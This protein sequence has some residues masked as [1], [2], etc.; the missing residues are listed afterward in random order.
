[1][2]RTPGG[3]RLE[4]V[5]GASR[6][7][8]ARTAP[9][10]VGWTAALGIGLGLAAG[11]ASRP[12]PEIPLVPV[13]GWDYVEGRMPAPG[14]GLSE[15]ATRELAA[16]WALVVA[17]RLGEADLQ[18]SPL[19]ALAPDDPGVLSAAGFFALRRGDRAEAGE[20]FQRALD[21][22]PD[23]VLAS[24]GN[25]LLILESGD[26]ELRFTRLRRLSELDPDAS[27]V[28]ERLP[29]LTLEV[30]ENRLA[31]ARE[32][33]RS[34][35]RG[36]RVA[37]AYR[38]ALQAM[39]DSA[40]L[41]LEAAE[42]AAAAG[43][44]PSARAWFETVASN[45]AASRR[46]ALGAGLAAAELLADERRFTES[47]T[48]LDQI[49][50][51][52]A[53]RGS[54]DLV[55][56]AEDLERRL[57]VARLSELYGRIREAE[58][59]TREQLAALLA[60]EIG[61]P[62]G[63]GGRSADPVIA[64]DLERSWAASLIQTAVGAGYLHLYPD[65]TF[66]PRG[67]VTRAELAQSLLAAFASFEPEARQSAGPDSAGLELRDV[68]PDHRHREAAAIAATLGLLR[69]SDDG[70]FRPRDF[71]SGAEAVRAVHALRDL[72]GRS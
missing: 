22:E 64:I 69:V 33:A 46:Q 39:P 41:F 50:G 72:L 30:A 34:D 13:A 17:G 45:P 25:V 56:R 58:R 53:V 36:P 51:D 59:V 11:C 61:A 15:G 20:L 14:P 48:A 40:D 49:L 32:L 4:G 47:L 71:A 44:R 6:R 27:V 52:P 24:L 38:A 35:E 37:E 16:S 28:S 63:D 23:D 57:E 9:S 8:A 29:R 70:N 18:L 7:P 26:P 3:V 10:A 21:A 43:D 67:L 62:E 19:R 12:P 55:A 2:A 5:F 42:A 68:P 66:Q 60:A 65:H 54:A 1:M 31:R